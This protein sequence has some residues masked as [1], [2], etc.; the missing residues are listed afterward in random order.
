MVTEFQDSRQCFQSGDLALRICNVCVST[1]V[2][3][4]ERPEEPVRHNVVGND[5]RD[6]AK[7]KRSEEGK[8]LTG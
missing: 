8:Y 7:A 2:K 3:Y 5:K 1:P 4:L 6:G